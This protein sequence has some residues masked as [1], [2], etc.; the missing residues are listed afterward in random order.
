MNSHYPKEMSSDKVLIIRRY[1]SVSTTTRVIA[2]YE[3]DKCNNVHSMFNL[4]HDILTH[5]MRALQS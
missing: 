2:Y 4:H 3:L 1:L 5:K